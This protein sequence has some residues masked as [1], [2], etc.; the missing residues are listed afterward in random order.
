MRPALV[1]RVKQPPE[2][3]TVSAITALLKTL[4]AGEPEEKFP[5]HVGGFT[6][7]FRYPKGTGEMRVFYRDGAEF[8]TR[9][10]DGLYKGSLPGPFLEAFGDIKARPVDEDDIITAWSFHFW[11]HPSEK[12]DQ[13]QAIRMVRAN[14]VMASELMLQ[15]DYTLRHGQMVICA[16]RAIEAKKNSKR[17]RSRSCVSKPAATTIDSTP[18]S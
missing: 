7:W 12:I 3:P 1:Q 5:A 17:T 15:I 9:M 16:N 6:L 10:R 18:T 2:E 13:T 8:V 11:S 4:E 14:P